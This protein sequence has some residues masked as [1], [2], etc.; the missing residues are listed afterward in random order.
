M[1][2]ELAHVPAAMMGLSHN[3]INTVTDYV[4][5]NVNLIKWYIYQGCPP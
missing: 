3:E 1:Q 2:L 5:F 4:L